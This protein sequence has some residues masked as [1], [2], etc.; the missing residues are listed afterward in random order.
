MKCREAALAHQENRRPAT[1]M[2]S[3]YLLGVHDMNR[4]GALRFKTD[5]NGEF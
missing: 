5:L 4:M 3:D 2:D 1:L